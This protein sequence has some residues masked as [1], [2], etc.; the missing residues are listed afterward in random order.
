LPIAQAPKLIDD[1]RNPVL[2]SSR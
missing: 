2:P 1:T